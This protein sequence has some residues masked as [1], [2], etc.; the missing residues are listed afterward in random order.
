MA[1]VS[2]PP[3][4]TKILCAKGVVETITVVHKGIH[5][6]IPSVSRKLLTK[7]NVFPNMQY[8]TYIITISRIRHAVD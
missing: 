3:P 6:Q 8:S 2:R 1:S 4:H 7:R 5:A